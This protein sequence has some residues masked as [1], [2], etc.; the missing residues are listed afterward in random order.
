[1]LSRRL[2]PFAAVAILVTATVFMGRSIAQTAAP[3]PMNDAARAEGTS[4]FAQR[5]AMCHEPPIE[6][7]PSRTDLA[8]YF[9]EAVKKA[10]VGGVMTA[11]AAGLTDSQINAVSLYLAGRE[12]RPVGDISA[13]D[14]NK[15]TAGS[16]FNPKG[17][18]WNGWSPDLRNTRFQA[19]PGLAASDVPKLQVKWA[20]GIEGGR[21]AQPSPVGNRVFVGSSSGRVYALDT[22]TGCVSWTFT[23]AVGVRTAPSVTANKA[24][25]SGY[26]VY[27]GDYDRNVYALDANSGKTL[28]SVNIETMPRQLLT[29]A[30]VAFK[31]VL[32]VPTSS[33]EETGATVAAYECCRARGSLVALDTVTGKVLWKSYTIKTE[34]A[35][36]RKNSVGVQLYGPAGAAIWSSPTIDARRGLVYVGTGDSYTDVDDEGASDAIIAFEMKSGAIRWKT[37]VTKHDNYIAGCRVGTGEGPVNCPQ[38]SGPDFDFGSPPILTR[39]GGRDMLVAGQK[40]GVVSAFD[41]DTGKILWQTKVGEGA[42]LGGIEWGM[43]VDDKNVYAPVAD[44]MFNGSTAGKPGLTALRLATGEL[45]WQAPAEPPKCGWQGR[46]GNG[47]SAPPSA[48]SGIVFSGSQDG[49]LRAFDAKNGKRVWDFDTAGQTYETVNGL[50]KQRGGQLDGSGPTIAGGQ[51]YMISGYNG[52]GGGGWSDN[53]LLAFSV[54]GR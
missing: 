23:S 38:P 40:S 3:G 52:S 27:F 7:A 18:A 51:L 26:A 49:H 29:G 33:F 16:R 46:C 9:P 39:A 14:R 12:P 47:Y 28:W 21:Y 50:K 48:I 4:I 24:A 6:R 13:E 34:P 10:L 37:Q 44:Q 2:S 36:F 45:A 11:M 31:G 19:H 32:F 22:G 5:C 30:P 17:P 35:P 1:M 53:V 15:C 8:N 41:P 43:A 54:N 25:A 42:A 20:F